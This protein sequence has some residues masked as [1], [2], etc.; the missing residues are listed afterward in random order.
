MHDRNRTVAKIAEAGDE[1]NF[2]IC[3][4]AFSTITAELTHE[5]NDVVHA[6]NMSFRKQAAVRVDRQFTAET[7][8]PPGRRTRRLHPWRKSPC[9]RAGIRQ[10]R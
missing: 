2:G 4:L 3:D 1:A 9:L 10:C 7:D 6:G 5:F 8:A